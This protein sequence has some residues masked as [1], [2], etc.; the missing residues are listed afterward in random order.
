MTPSVPSHRHLLV[1]TSVT[2]IQL[3]SCHN[4][5]IFPSCRFLSVTLTPSFPLLH[6]GTFLVHWLLPFPS[7]RH[8]HATMAPSLHT[9]TFLS[10]WH[11]LF[12]FVQTDTFMPH[13][14]L[15]RVFSAVLVAFL[16]FD[17][18]HYQIVA[19]IKI[20]KSHI[21]SEKAQITCTIPSLHTDTFLSI[22]LPF[23][24]I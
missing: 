10:Q 3:H 19:N 12:L 1:T 2:F 5:T 24:L 18:C 15:V 21:T 14:H 22:H 13:L 8:L 6:A 9:D 17:T 23:P 16:Y 7:Y 4:V 11:L 20:W